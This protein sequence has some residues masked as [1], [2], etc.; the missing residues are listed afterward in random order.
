VLVNEN[1]IPT[2]E[3]KDVKGTPMDFSTAHS[4][5]ER[6][7]LVDG[8]YDHTY[9]LLNEGNVLKVA[10]VFDPQSGRG[11]EVYTSEPGM[12]FYTGNFL[13]GTLTGKNGIVYNQHHGFCLETQHFPDSPNQPEFPSA[14]LNPGEEYAQKTIYKFIIK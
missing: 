9:V 8:G 14:I 4:I 2:G 11:M 1:L 10:D 6:I 12:Q 5:G 7:S 3:L 13:D